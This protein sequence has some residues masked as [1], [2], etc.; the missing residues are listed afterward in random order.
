MESY[1]KDLGLEEGASFNEVKKAFRR[2]AVE[3]HPDKT[4]DDGATFKKICEAYNAIKDMQEGERSFSLKLRGLIRHLKTVED[5]ASIYIAVKIVDMISILHE[6]VEVEKEM[7]NEGYRMADKAD[8][9][10]RRHFTD[11]FFENDEDQPYKKRAYSEFLGWREMF[12]AI[13]DDYRREGNLNK[14]CEIAD[15]WL[16]Y[17]EEKSQ[18]IPEGNSSADIFMRYFLKKIK[19]PLAEITT[20]PRLGG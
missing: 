7:I 15:R 3:N 2:L 4:N 10:E 8:S 17:A 5:K 20:T 16:E 9:G 12:A 1:Y 11:F 13:I 18:L 14:L 6:M 19:K